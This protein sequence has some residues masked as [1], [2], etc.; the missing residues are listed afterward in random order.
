MPIPIS[1]SNG[2]S[3]KT[4]AAALEHFKAMLAR[5]A[6]DSIVD[7]R[8]DHEDLVALLERYDEAIVEGPS[9]TGGGIDHFTRTRNAFN[10]FSTPSFWVHRIDGSATDFSYL[11]AVKG[12]PRG[13]SGEFYD[14]CRAAVQDDLI[15]AKRRF[16]TH[17][18]DENGCVPCELT[19]AAIAFS[20]AHL[21]HAWPSF[22][23]IVASFRAAH[24]WTREI[25]SGVVTLPA[26]A[27]TQSK[28]VDSSVAVAFNDMHHN[29]A[30]L[31]IVSSKINLSMAGRQ[32]RP[33]VRRPIRLQDDDGS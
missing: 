29:L 26:D 10:G 8:T 11:S 2:R 31:R 6:D 22:G 1:L 19:G 9:K 20:E 24:S 16:F 30:V 12:Q 7:D 5:Y 33:T 27:Q 23:Q 13:R 3:W 25:P 17:H 18:G 21:D 4:K 28:F 32:R 14:A 15:A